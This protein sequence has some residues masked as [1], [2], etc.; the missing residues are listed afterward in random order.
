MRAAGIGVQQ[1]INLIKIANNDLQ[2]VEQKYQKLKRDVNS[3]ESRKLEEYRTLNDLQDQTAGSWLI[4]I[5]DEVC[6]LT[7]FNFQ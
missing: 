2:A 6:R 4:R 7:G 5:S 1:S 3:L